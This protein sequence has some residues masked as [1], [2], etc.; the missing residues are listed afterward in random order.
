[1]RALQLVQYNHTPDAFAY[2]DQLAKP[3]VCSPFQVL[4]RIKAAGT[5]PVDA[6]IA[7]GELNTS[8][9]LPLP[10][11]IGADFSGIVEAIGNQVEDFKVGDHVFGSL[12]MPF[13]MGTYAEY[14]LVDTQ[15]DSIA[16]KPLHLSFEE[17]ASAGIGV[18]TAY[19]GIVKNS[20]K[21]IHQK[22]RILV[23]GA[24]GGV[25]V[26]GI[27]VAKA[28][29]PHNTVVGICSGRN[30]EFVKSLGADDVIDYTD[31]QKYEQFIRDNENSFD[32]VF[33]CVGGDEYYQQLDP[34]LNKTGVFS[35]AVVPKGYVKANGGRLT[36]IAMSY[37]S[38]YK[39]V[40]AS[41]AY[42]VVV[43]LPHDDFRSKIAPL[44]DTK[45]VSGLVHSENKIPL[46]DGH[47]AH[48]KLATR[49]TVGKIVLTM[50]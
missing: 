24:S 13:V 29:H 8:S 23:V 47:L 41:H 48:Q 35:T 38:F 16:K 21:D 4:V 31:K 11:I 34:L 22:M 43:S 6:K 44:F 28:I 5:N 3:S 40:F 45:A 25:G 49:R 39:H 1:M 7:S 17:A 14:T 26:F 2:T 27:Q 33:D 37:K 9:F 50:E 12:H 32:L 30:V 36:A 18:L 19:Q 46:K 20:P 42:A 10:C 15:K